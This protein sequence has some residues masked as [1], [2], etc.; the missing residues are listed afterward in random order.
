MRSV[1]LCLLVLAV[2]I[3]PLAMVPTGVK[4]ATVQEEDAEKEESKPRL[5]TEASWGDLTPGHQPVPGPSPDEHEDAAELP[6]LPPA[7]YARRLHAAPKPLAPPTDP[8]RAELC[9]GH[10]DL[11]PP[12]A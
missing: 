6:D 9:A 8:P 5:P 10:L 7:L 4:P 3:A 2:A 1:L 12:A 11:P